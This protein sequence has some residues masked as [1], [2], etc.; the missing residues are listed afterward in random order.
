MKSQKTN[1]AG[2]LPGT[3]TNKLVIP[4]LV[5]LGALLLPLVPA[6]AAVYNFELQ[7]RNTATDADGNM[8]ATTGQGIFDT[9]TGTV[10]ATGSFTMYDSSGAVVSKGTWVATDF[11]SFNASGGVNRGFQTGTL[12]ISSTLRPTGGAAITGVPM[13]VHCDE[14]ELPGPVEAGNTD[15]TTVGDFTT[16]TGGFTL[17]QLISP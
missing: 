9:T 12:A 17:F 2:P 13:T 1:Q 3:K 4:S 11:V 6:R 15:G 10:K 14:D 16:T 8:I 5:L 7:T